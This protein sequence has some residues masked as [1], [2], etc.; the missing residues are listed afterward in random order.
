MSDYQTYEYE[1]KR[2]QR[3]DLTPEEYQKAIA[4]LAKRL[5]I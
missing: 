2:I 4:E 3:M 1:K 5:G